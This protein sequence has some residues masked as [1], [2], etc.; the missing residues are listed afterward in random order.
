MST[1]IQRLVDHDEVDDDLIEALEKA[2]TGLKSPKADYLV[3]L[4]SRVSGEA[5][6]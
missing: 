5:L 4:I 2:L 3:D 1:F 6:A